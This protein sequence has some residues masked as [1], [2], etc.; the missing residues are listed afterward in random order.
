VTITL[1]GFQPQAAVVRWSEGSRYGISFNTV[2]PLAG[3][4]EWLQGRASA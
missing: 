1:P 4:T 2:L 3:L